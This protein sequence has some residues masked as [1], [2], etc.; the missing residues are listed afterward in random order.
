VSHFTHPY[1]EITR[2]INSN[3]MVRSLDRP[4]NDGSMAK[5]RRRIGVTF[6][7]AVYQPLTF[8]QTGLHKLSTPTTTLNDI[9]KINTLYTG[10]QGHEMAPIDDCRQDIKEGLRL[11]RVRVVTRI[12]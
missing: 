6:Q 7:Q 5:D 11:S 2:W 1:V 9:E 8:D 10:H 4:Q 12:L 3:A